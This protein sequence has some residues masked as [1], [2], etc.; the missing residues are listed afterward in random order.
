MTKPLE[1][2]VAVCR[3]LTLADGKAPEWIHLLPIDPYFDGADGRRF[4]IDDADAIVN[5]FDRPLIVDEDHES[6]Q[7][8]GS[9]EAS[10]WVEE[11]RVV[12]SSDT[13]FDRPGIWGR[14]D[15][16]PEGALCVQGKSYRYISPAFYR[17]FDDDGIQH[18]VKMASVGLTN[19]PNLNLKSLNRASAFAP[20]AP[21]AEVSKLMNAEQLA[22]LKAACGLGADASNDV[23]FVALNSKATAK[24]EVSVN[25]DT[26]PRAD[27]EVALNRAKAAEDALAV[28]AKSA[29][30]VAVNAAVEGAKRDGKIAP[31]SEAHYR[32]LCATADG[33]RM[34]TELFASLPSL[35]GD[36]P[37]PVKPIADAVSA[38]SLNAAEKRMA[39]RLGLTEKQAL[40]NKKNSNGGAAV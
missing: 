6:E 21:V 28:H 23:L 8:N 25:T 7:Y 32:T 26:V 3:V 39:K 40:D 35:V 16:T 19:Q 11:L 17:W 29:H 38:T 9:S 4:A 10:G 18:V 31:A 2:D 1:L 27:L 37:V 36:A 15:W 12:R 22:A 14:V 20:K 24:P 33:L 34:A 13:T 5:A 30:E